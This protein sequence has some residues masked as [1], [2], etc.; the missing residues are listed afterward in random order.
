MS[1]RARAVAFALT[2]LAMAEPA[3]AQP[4]DAAV[5]RKYPYDSDMFKIERARCEE[6]HDGP[7]C[8]G[9]A[10][11]F[12]W[13][14]SP[15]YDGEPLDAE[16]LR[17]QIALHQRGCDLGY[18]QSCVELAKHF[19]LG[20]GV[21]RDED[22]ARQLAARACDAKPDGWTDARGQYYGAVGAGCVVLSQL[23]A[24][25][26][27]VRELLTRA[28]QVGYRGA[29]GQIFTNDWMPGYPGYVD[30]CGSPHLGERLRPHR[31]PSPAKRR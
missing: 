11:L 2:V 16:Q 23:T 29:K 28:C 22:R 3:R 1:T 15:Y 6:R 25:P 18:E 7:A 26:K 19:A 21:P 31:Q 14:P 9:A 24:D 10:V 12:D 13:S 8:Y 27:R 4:P 17:D 20:T 5:R 30:A